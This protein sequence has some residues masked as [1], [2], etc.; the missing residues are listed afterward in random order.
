MNKLTISLAYV[1]EKNFYCSRCRTW[2]YCPEMNQKTKDEQG[3]IVNKIGEGCLKQDSEGEY[4]ECPGCKT[5]FYL[6]D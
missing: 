1:L 6:T 3:N 2:I 4:F 5:H